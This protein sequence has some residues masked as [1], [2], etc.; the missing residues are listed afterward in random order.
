M[1]NE[2]E[3][4]GLLIDIPDG[5]NGN[6]AKKTAPMGAVLWPG[7]SVPFQM[8]G[9]SDAATI[10]KVPHSQNVTHDWKKKQNK[11]V[12]LLFCMQARGKKAA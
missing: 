4:T 9:Q 7:M 5:L 8:A 6:V 12:N 3:Q 11:H 1:L 2:G 10:A